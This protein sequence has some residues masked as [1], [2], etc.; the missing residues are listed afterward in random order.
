MDSK[1]LVYRAL[2][3]EEIPRT[4]Y[5]IDFTV[6]A[7][8]RLR[9]SEVGR[10]LYDAVEND[11]VLT[12]VIR[13]E[14]G[15]RDSH[16]SYRDEFG[17]EWD[18]RIDPDIGIP[19]P[20]VSPET[21]RGT[22]LPDPKAPDRFD[23]LKRNLAEHPERFHLLAMDFSLYERAWA[24][25]GLES[26]YV[27]MVERP[28]FVEALLDRILEFNLQ[29]IEEG[30]RRCPAVDG[31]HFGDDFGDQI[32]VPMGAERWRALIKPRLARQYGMVKAAGKK[33]SIHSCGKVLQ[34]L[35]DLVEIGVDLFNPFQPEVMDVETVLRR[36]RGRLSFWGGISTQRLLPFASPEEV[37][38]RVEELIALGRSGGYVVA[39]AHA[40]P[41]DATER[42]LHAMLRALMN[43]KQMAGTGAR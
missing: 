32:G 1:E 24:M 19:K 9:S 17:Q 30:L 6:P 4:P 2:G 26:F 18:R 16:G 36:F 33:V 7:L 38:R 29:V 43:Q 21:L 25:R 20:F 13:V 10:A 42:N 8:A 28:E 41:A 15:K 23:G 37:T 39:P 3:F 35:D 34:I 27:D 12:P 14:W 31:V 40:V 5:S 11:V 22:R